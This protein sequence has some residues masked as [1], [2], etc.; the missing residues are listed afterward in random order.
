M[1][2]TGQCIV[3]WQGKKSNRNT[4]EA[5]EKLKEII[6]RLRLEGG[7]VP[8]VASVLHDVEEEEKEDLVSK[9]VRSLLWLLGS[10]G[11]VSEG[12]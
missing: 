6:L 8:E 7:Y 10:Q 3:L 1:K 9:K 4:A 12:L 5:Y 2:L 11:C